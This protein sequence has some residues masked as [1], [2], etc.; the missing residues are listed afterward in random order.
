M[1]MPA[2][3]VSSSGSVRAALRWMSSAVMTGVLAGSRRTASGKRVAVTITG[4][5]WAR[6]TETQ[7]AAIKPVAVRVARCSIE[8]LPGVF[9]D[10]L[11]VE[12]ASRPVSGLARLPSPLPAQLRRSGLAGT[13]HSLTVAGAVQDLHLFPEHLVARANSSP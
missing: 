4:S 12:K 9:P 11:L 10:A 1:V 8:N 3:P 2:W 6:Q 7:A 5:C 13:A